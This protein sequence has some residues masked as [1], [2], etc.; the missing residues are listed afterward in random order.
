MRQ[1]EAMNEVLLIDDD[2]EFCELL[3]EYLHGRGFAVTAVHDG[4]EG[5]VTARQPGPEIIIL[6]VMLPSMDGIEVLRELRRASELPVLMLTARGDDVD[7]IVG[8]ELGAD[9]YLAKPCNPREVAARLQAIL[10][11]SG[12]A[13]GEREAFEVG[14]LHLDSADRSVRVGSAEVA[15]T[16]TEFSVLA[17]LVRSA[18]SVVTKERMSE[19]GLGRPLG[20]HDRALDMHLSHLRRKLGPLPDGR[21]RI[22]TVRGVGYQLLRP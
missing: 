1:N 9:D 21:D 8:L 7:R 19:E 15:V 12:E 2:R 20:R 17:V 22:E 13:R 10:R 18:G 16:S 4:E 3:S 11:R 14:D 6:D 5:L